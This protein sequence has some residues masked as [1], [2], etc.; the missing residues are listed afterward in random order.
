MSGEADGRVN[1]NDAAALKQIDGDTM[2]C[3]HVESQLASGDTVELVD[4]LRADDR[5][6]LDDGFGYGD[7][8]RIDAVGIDDDIGVSEYHARTV[9]HASR[10]RRCELFRA[11]RSS[12]RDQAL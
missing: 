9:R 3:R 2:A 12:A 6:C 10:S 7:L 4:D 11:L 1:G 8:G 5:R